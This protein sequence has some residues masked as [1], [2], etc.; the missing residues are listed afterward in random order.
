MV[1]HKVD[2]GSGLH[3][4]EAPGFTHTLSKDHGAMEGKRPDVPA[5]TVGER[6]PEDA[7]CSCAADC[8]ASLKVLADPNRILIVRALIRQPLSVGDI[9]A[10]T[11]LSQQR[12]S[13]HLGRMRPAGIVQAERDGRSIIYRISPRIAV[14][15]G[16]DLGCC[17]IVFRAIPRLPRLPRPQA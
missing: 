15:G 17:R 1:P 8:A 14:E 10:A 6:L 16:I 11:G 5:D 13:H 9:C 4:A 12:V 3:S 7:M 2:S